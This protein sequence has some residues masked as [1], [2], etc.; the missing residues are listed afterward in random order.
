[1]AIVMPAAGMN[2]VQLTDFAFDAGG[3]AGLPSSAASVVP[4]L[5]ALVLGFTVFVDA[6]IDCV[7]LGICRGADV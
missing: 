5:A 3:G 7:W 1:M 4:D 6:T 2:F